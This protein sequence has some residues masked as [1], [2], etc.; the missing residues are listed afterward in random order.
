MERH[1]WLFSLDC[2]Q[3]TF[4]PLTTS[5]L[6]A[7]YTKHGKT[8]G[9]T[10][11][12]LIHYRYHS[13][14]M[15]W[16][17]TE[18][19]TSGLERARR[20]L[21]GGVRP[22]AAFSCYTW[23]MPTFLRMIRTMKESCPELLVV[24]GGPHVQYI[25]PYVRGAGIDAIVL[26][27]GE[28]TFTELLDCDTEIRESSIPGLAYEGP[29][30]A[31]VRTPARA[32]LTDLDTLP[33]PLTCVPFADPSGRP[34][35]WAAYETM[36]GC[37]YRCAF[38]QW[39]TGAIGVKVG[40][41]ALDRVRDDLER[42]VRGGIEGLLFCDSNFGAMPDDGEKA[43]WLVGLKER[44]GRPLH[45]A[46]CWSKEQNRRVQSVIRRLH[47]ARLLEHYT[48]ALQ[49]LTPAALRTS[50]RV[51]M[52][53]YQ[54][55]VRG[56]VQDGVPIVS[57][58]IWGLPGETFD[59]FANN[60]DVLTA[61]FPSHT[62]Y[63]YAM[64]PGTE[65]FDRREELGIET[66]ELAP[67]GDAR[68][69]YIIACNSFGRSE[70]LEGYA[71]ITAAILLYRGNIIPLTLRY[72]ALRKEVSMSRV[73]RAVFRELAE[74]FVEGFPALRG[75]DATGLFEQREFIYRWILKHRA[76]AFEI[77]HGAAARE[78]ERSGR[79]AMLAPVQRLLLLDEALC[80][81]KDE[82]SAVPASFDFDVEKTLAALERMDLPDSEYLEPGERREVLVEHG[83]EYGD[84]VVPRPHT[85]RNGA[86]R[87]RY[88]V[89][90]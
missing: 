34:Y 53:D 4:L 74:R 86:L 51:N 68:A 6:K 62:I 69:D 39:G 23:N 77:I 60:L 15:R 27:E 47:Q 19:Q 30:G 75:A 90:P 8:A 50:N 22:V 46:T 45:F 70:G 49:T 3:F 24:A 11:V 17:A 81:R 16:L 42:I 32:R 61:V 79:P 88:H 85:A 18:W 72:L 82:R 40:R 87:G 63:P 28:V 13:D 43:E 33:S 7:Y 48:M 21:A 66:V 64:L 55:V 89:W 41:F 38:C 29:D 80:P 57:E 36:R 25:D 54:D 58:L 76:E 56:M 14:A 20:S 44:F 65:L 35:R 1:V 31:V 26:G 12:D 37:P 83:W 71:L 52:P 67:Y 2:E 59:D 73:L 10:H 84:D 5:G 9:N 78:I